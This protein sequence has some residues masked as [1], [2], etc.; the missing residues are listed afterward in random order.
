MKD[1]KDITDSITNNQLDDNEIIN[2]LRY[3]KITQLT[4]FGGKKAY[5]K[6]VIGEIEKK[7]KV[8]IK[9]TNPDH[10]ITKNI[11]IQDW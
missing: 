8:V 6:K 4:S 3:G 2:F 1:L 5:S 7:T 9:M 10:S 11:E